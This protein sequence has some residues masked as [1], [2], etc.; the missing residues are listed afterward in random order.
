LARTTAAAAVMT[1]AATPAMAQVLVY[2]PPQRQPAARVQLPPPPPIPRLAQDE[3]SLS[4][5]RFGLTILS[6]GTVEALR[7][8]RGVTVQPIVSQFGWQF[9]HSFDVNDDGLSV[10]TEFVPLLSGLEQGLALPSLNWMVGIRT[11][12]GTEFGLGPNITPVG[13]GLVLAGGVTVRTGSLNVPLTFAFA[14]S[15]YGPRISIMT[16]FNIRR[17]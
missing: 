4:G 5:P 17:R 6:P 7:R 15:K 14:S 10:V 13:V 11:G 1:V 16:G 8:D 3:I 2:R 12:A 9:E